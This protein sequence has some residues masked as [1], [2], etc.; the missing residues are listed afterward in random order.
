MVSLLSNQG[1]KYA[2]FAI[3]LLDAYYFAGTMDALSNPLVHVGIVASP[4]DD[5]ILSCEVGLEK[6]RN[7][8]NAYITGFSLFMF[9]VLRR[10]TS[11]RGFTLAARTEPTV[12]IYPVGSSTSRASSS[13]RARQTSRAVGCPWAS[14]WRRAASQSA[15]DGL[16]PRGPVLPRPLPCTQPVIVCL[17]GRTPTAG[18]CIGSCTI[19]MY[20]LV[21]SRMLDGWWR[22]SCRNELLV[23]MS[24]STGF[25]CARSA[26][27]LYPDTRGAR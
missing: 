22:P 4:I 7:E 21:G 2:G 15:T 23:L 6:F 8:R 20:V 12:P 17:F 10:L 14:R 16:A 26:P 9:L 18:S 27:V 11:S 5:V 1:V 13:T 19:N 3:L 24:I 25:S